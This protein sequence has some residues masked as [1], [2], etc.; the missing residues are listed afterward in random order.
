[1]NLASRLE[2]ASKKGRHTRIVLSES[3]FNA[4]SEL[5]EAEEMPFT[6]VTGKQQP[7][8]MFELVRL[9]PVSETRPA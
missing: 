3:T 8:R 2:T 1:M 7:V 9:R 4:V 6:E 5:V